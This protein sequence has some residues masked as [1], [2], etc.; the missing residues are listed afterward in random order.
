MQRLLEFIF[1]LERGFLSRDGEL[2]LQFNPAWPGQ[3]YV[4]AVTW[5]VLLAVAAAMLVWYVYR[6]EGRSRPVR[7]T[8]GIMRGVLLAFL[9]VLLNR[10][11][12]TLGQSR[13]EPSVLAVMIDDSISMRVRDAQSGAVSRLEAVISTMSAG[14]RALMNELAKKHQVRLYRFS[15]DQEAISQEGLA[16]LEP[17]G[18][19]TQILPAIRGVLS[20]LQGQ[21]LAG[22]V[23]LTDGRETPV[24]A[25]GEGL[26]AVKNFGVKVYPVAVGSDKA[27]TN[28][29]I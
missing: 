2:S 21:R 15:S 4:G 3:D 27:P 12:L 16:K 1:G 29:D 5:N 23:L 8:L 10:P 19:H 17:T 24:S 22:V 13:T 14:D 28:I 25:L 20:D 18:Q 9:L 11:L 7:I 6:R 26:A